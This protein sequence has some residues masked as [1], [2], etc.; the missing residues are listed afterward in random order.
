MF[1]A[2]LSKFHVVTMISNTAR[3]RSRYNIYRK[4]HEMIKA[5]GVNFTLVELAFGERPF[6]ITERDNDWHVQL[7]TQ[8]ELWHKENGINV[9]I[10]YVCQEHPDAKY[11]AWIDPDVFPMRTPRDWFEETWH[12]LQ[13]YHVVQM[14]EHAIDLDPSYSV[15]SKPHKSFMAAYVQSGFK[16]PDT[17]GHWYYYG[18]GHP[19]YAW[20]ASR[21]A[22]NHLGGLIDF[23]ILGAADRH[24]ALGL[25]HSIEQSFPGGISDAYQA[26]LLQ[27]QERAKKHIRLDV[28]YVPGDIYHYFHGKKKDRKYADRWKILVDTQY[29]PNTDLKRDAQGL[30]QVEDW[31]PRQIRLRDLLRGYFRARNEDSIDL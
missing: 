26:E 7:R 2:D 8:D 10:N 20:A 25:V 4:W 23:A 12:Q 29:D 1:E 16:L 3:Y 5:A 13:H 30:W 22:L 21:E 6:E 18:H 19:G 27:W 17:K 14:F 24:M 31:D 28:G 11:F 15:M 9:A